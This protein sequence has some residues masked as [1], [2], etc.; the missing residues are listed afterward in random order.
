V[1]SVCL[2]DVVAGCE[3]RER[4]KLLS[5]VELGWVEESCVER[6]RDVRGRERDRVLPCF[7]F[8]VCCVCMLWV[9]RERETGKSLIAVEEG[10]VERDR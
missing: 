7:C 1:F 9:E 4:E 6:E 10:R 8:C 5:A 2:V 3:S